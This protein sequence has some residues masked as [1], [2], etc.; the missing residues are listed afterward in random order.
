MFKSKTG[1]FSK[2]KYDFPASIVVFLVALP[3]CLG[4]ALASDAP[5]FSGVIAGIVGGVLVGLLS[6]SSIGVSG[7][8]AGLTSIV[9]GAILSLGSFEVFLYAVF[10]AGIFQIL[11]G[12][13]KAGVIGYYFPNSVIKGMLAAIGVILFR[14]QIP[15][16]FGYDKDPEG[17]LDFEKIDGEH[18][19]SDLFY[20]TDDISLGAIVITVISLLVLILWE[21]KF[22]KSK[23]IFKIVQGPLVVVILGIVLKSVFDGIVSLK[24]SSEHLVKLP[25]MNSEEGLGSLLTFPDF[26]AWNNPDVYLVALT[27]ALVASIETLLCVEATDK[28][29]PDKRVTPTNR[30]LLAQ[31][32]GNMVSG[33]IGGLP[34]T[35]VIVRSSANIHSGGKTKASAFFHG[36]LLFLSVILIP[37]VLNLIPFAALAAILLMVAYKLAKPATFVEMYKKGWDQYVPFF[38]TVV[39]INVNGV[40]LLWGIAI[41]L[42][43]G[44][45]IILLKNF[46]NPFHKELD[47][48][49]EEIKLQLSQIVSFLNKAYILK[50]LSDI[51][52]DKKVVID[53]RSTRYI[54]PVSYTHL[55]LPTN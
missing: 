26:S 54:H 49:A 30:E 13:V 21:T 46:Q 9:A 24:I 52:N 42:A 3:L 53:A 55:T 2:L 43:V 6:G 23:P 35:Q 18:V 15:H 29:D 37:D 40:G 5:A 8:A 51:K 11:L 47:L 7:P 50:T 38:I 16:A 10:V 25:V 27:I 32:T 48:E 41:G 14:K 4:I 31:G 33:L 1:L 20:F 19:F 45:F 22:F 17:S 12:Y 36:I 28:L 44:F 34:V 39:L